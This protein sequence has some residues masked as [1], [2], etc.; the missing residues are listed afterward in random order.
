[1]GDPSTPWSDRSI[2]VMSD[3]VRAS[4]DGLRAVDGGSDAIASKSDE[5]GKVNSEHAWT[6]LAETNVSVGGTDGGVSASR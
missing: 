1:M 3:G 5:R 6:W 2:G 4:S